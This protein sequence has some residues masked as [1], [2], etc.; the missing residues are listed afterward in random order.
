MYN[1]DYTRVRQYRPGLNITLNEDAAKKRLADPGYFQPTP[2]W[3]KEDSR[4]QLWS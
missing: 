1:T 3:D 2:E 4:E